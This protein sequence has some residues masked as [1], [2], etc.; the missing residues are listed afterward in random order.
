[1]DMIT[2]LKKMD[3]PAICARAGYSREE[4]R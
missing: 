3:F 1:M 4:Y 2:E